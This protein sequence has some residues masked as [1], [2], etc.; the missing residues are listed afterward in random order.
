MVAVMMTAMTLTMAM[1]MTKAMMLRM[2]MVTVAM[3]MVEV[4]V[5]AMAVMTMIPDFQGGSKPK[6]SRPP[7]LAA[8]C[9]ATYARA[10]L[11]ACQRQ[12]H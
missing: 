5:E 1:M 10:T 11:H 12:A 6:R 8:D 9:P 4:M 3:V 7:Q 2:T